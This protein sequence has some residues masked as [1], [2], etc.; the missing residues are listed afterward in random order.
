MGY[1]GYVYFN[2]SRLFSE[3]KFQGD[4]CMKYAETYN[5]QK[6][7][8]LEIKSIEET[9]KNI[10]G[11]VASYSRYAYSISVAS[12]IIREL[13]SLLDGGYES[14][15]D[16]NGIFLLVPKLYAT[17]KNGDYQVIN[18]YPKDKVPEV[19]EISENEKT[20]YTE[21][22]LELINKNIRVSIKPISI[23]SAISD[24]YEKN[25]DTLYKNFINKVLNVKCR[26]EMFAVIEEMHEYYKILHKK[27]ME[28]Y[29]FAKKL[30]FSLECCKEKI[31]NGEEVYAK[32]KG[33]IL[34]LYTKKQYISIEY[35][36]FF[37]IANLFANNG[38]S[39]L[40]AGCTIETIEEFEKLIETF[41]LMPKNKRNYSIEQ[42]LKKN[43]ETVKSTKEPFKVSIYGGY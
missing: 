11:G 3:G 16:E 1:S 19:P 5:K 13:S 30:T 17:N 21:E 31:R 37:N 10:N 39:S 9:I 32:I 29:D 12:T 20:S 34:Y 25:S 41:E 33:N 23:Y 38:I 2:N 40:D 8:K 7:A 14:Y 18:F 36:T 35:E 6:A 15:F 43:L 22:Q 4:I 24:T 27:Y 28:K 26:N 42:Q